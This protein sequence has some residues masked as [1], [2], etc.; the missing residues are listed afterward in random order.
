MQD[1]LDEIFNDSL[2]YAS[3]YVLTALFQMCLGIISIDFLNRSAIRQITRI[4]QELFQS[5]LRQEVAWYDISS[6]KVNFAAC[7][8]EY[9]YHMND[10]FVNKIEIFIIFFSLQ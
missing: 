5:M 4:R 8:T 6:G 2:A 3:V 9:V 10:V 7:I 1:S